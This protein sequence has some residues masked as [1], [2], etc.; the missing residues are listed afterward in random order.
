MKTFLTALCLCVSLTA[1]AQLGSG[2]G[3]FGTIG[4]GTGGSNSYT[5]PIAS[6]STLGGVKVGSGLSING[7]GVLSSTGGGGTN[8]YIVSTNDFVLNQ[9]YTNVSQQ[10]FVASSIVLN[11]TTTTLVQVSLLVDQDANGTWESSGNSASSQSFGVISPITTMQQLSAIVQPGGR[12]CFTNQSVG[13]ASINP[14]SSQWIALSTSNS[15]SGGGTGQVVTNGNN[16]Y[17]LTSTNNFLG[18]VTVSNETIIG[19]LSQTDATKTNTM[20]GVTIATNSANQYGVGVGKSLYQF[21][22][23]NYNASGSSNQVTGSI[24][25]NSTSLTVS[26]ASDFAVGQGIWILGAG[27]KGS[28]YTNLC[29]T[30]TAISGT[31]FTLANIASNTVASVRVQHDDSAA[32]NAAI[33]VA[34]TNNGGVVYF[35]KTGCAGWYRCNGPFSAVTQSIL[36]FPQNNNYV[37]IPPV[38]SL[39]GEVRGSLGVSSSGAIVNPLNG[40]IIDSVDGPTTGGGSEQAILATA[41]YVVI[42]S[43]NISTSFNAVDVHVDNLM[44]LAANN[45]TVW[46]LQLANALR[47]TIGD[48]VIVT[49]GTYTALETGGTFGI[50][51]P[52]VRNNVVVNVGSCTVIGFDGGIL[53]SDS[54]RLN[55]PF[56]AWCEYGLYVSFSSLSGGHVISGSVQCLGCVY[57]LRTDDVVAVSCIPLD[58][59]CSFENVNSGPF[60]NV[61][62]VYDGSDVLSGQVR[63]ELLGNA[64][65]NKHNASSVTFTKLT[66]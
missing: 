62:D 20:A 9:Y 55:R 15:A 14:G 6:A 25:S 10:S 45:P 4:S 59:T 29:T 50:Y 37:D 12:F 36:T 60:T 7:S 46:G 47:A 1:L 48:G 17:Q 39:L 56:I 27:L 8:G 53:A 41:P 57:N 38:I 22:V 40:C 11:P 2:Q 43:G 33:A 26:S 42:T 23:L 31:T 51:L 18:P 63:Y 54:T 44:I 34:F 5:L 32:I 64:N 21:N 19:S 24:S 58:L 49:G 52:Q 16:A 35:P 13:V 30:I 28:G 66:K 3:S 65:I 61:W